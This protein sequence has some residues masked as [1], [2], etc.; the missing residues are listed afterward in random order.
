MREFDERIER[1]KQVLEDNAT[2]TGGWL[3]HV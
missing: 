2:V 1:N 3:I